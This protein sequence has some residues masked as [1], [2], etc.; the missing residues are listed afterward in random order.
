MKWPHSVLLCTIG[1]GFAVS[2]YAQRGSGAVP[3]GDS[4]VPSSPRA[5]KLQLRTPFTLTYRA[6]V[7]GVLHN[8]SDRPYN[9]RMTLSYDGKNLLYRSKDLPD[10]RTVT[11][12]YDG[13]ETY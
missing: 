3:R 5:Q 6:H 10:G 7:R 12:L 11:L 13:D 1:S 2:A 8:G 9:V 4:I